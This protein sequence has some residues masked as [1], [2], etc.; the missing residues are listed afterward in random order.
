MLREE[1]FAEGTPAEYREGAIGGKVGRAVRIPFRLLQAGDNYFRTL[2]TEAELHKAA[3][4]QAKGDWKKAQEIIKQRPKELMAQIEPKVA[5]RLFQDPNKLAKFII[6][7]RNTA[8]DLPRN[9]AFRSGPFKHRHSDHPTLP[10]GLP[11]GA[12]ELERV[13]EGREGWSGGRRPCRTQ[14]KGPG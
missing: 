11:E 4:R 1:T 10:V 7:A 14:G 13:P 6:D 9:C 3:Y 2:G 5:E 12:Q 8:P